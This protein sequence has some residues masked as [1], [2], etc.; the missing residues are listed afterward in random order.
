[1]PSAMLTADFKA[2]L[3]ALLVRARQGLTAILCAEAEPWRCHRSLIA[4]SLLVRG[5]AVNDIYG[6][7][8]ARPHKL[9]SIAHVVGTRIT[10]PPTALDSAPS[11]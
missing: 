2:S 11:D 4:V 7:S 8:R 6:P 3:N 1:M 5:V 10:Y 9:T